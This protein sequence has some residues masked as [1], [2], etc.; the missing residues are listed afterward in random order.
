[1]LVAQEWEPIHIS[2]CMRE[3]WRVNA[4]AVPEIVAQHTGVVLQ[5]VT[6]RMV[7]LPC[8]PR[9]RIDA[10]LLFQRHGAFAF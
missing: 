6:R 1:M 3:V 7:P 9:W 2:N 5:A 10:I 8:R 4:K